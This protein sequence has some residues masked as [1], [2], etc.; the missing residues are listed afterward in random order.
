MK[1]PLILINYRKPW[2]VFEGHEESVTCLD[3]DEEVLVSGSLDRSVRVWSL[4]SS[5]L[6]RVLRREGSPIV[7]IRLLSD[8]LLWWAK[9][10]NFQISSWETYN[11]VDL[12]CRFTIQEDPIKCIMCIGE[13]Y[14]VTNQTNNEVEMK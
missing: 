6:L 12:K 1:L 13:N 10:G 14:I 5:K 4:E 9:S 7:T 2:R 11:K 8:R 3:V